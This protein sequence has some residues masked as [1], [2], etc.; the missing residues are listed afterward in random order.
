MVY[1]CENTVTR[2]LGTSGGICRRQERM[3]GMRSG[4]GQTSIV[5][6]MMIGWSEGEGGGRGKDVEVHMDVIQYLATV[7]YSTEVTW[8]ST[9]TVLITAQKYMY[10]AA[11]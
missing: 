9:C 5:S 3:C 4:R 10:L 8:V 2:Y 11:T 1:V 6:G 7:Q